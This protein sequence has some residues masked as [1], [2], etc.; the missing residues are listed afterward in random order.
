MFVEMEALPIEGIREIFLSSIKETFPHV[1]K[2]TSKEV[3]SFTIFIKL[4]CIFLKDTK[5]I[6]KVNQEIIKG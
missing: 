3:L 4:C 6:V 5:Q 1:T 2:A